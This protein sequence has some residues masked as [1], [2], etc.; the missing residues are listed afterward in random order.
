MQSLAPSGASAVYV[1]QRESSETAAARRLP[2]PTWCHSTRCSCVVLP[3]RPL[4]L[5]AVRHDLG[6]TGSAE[7]LLRAVYQAF[8]HLWNGIKF[9]VA[10]DKLKA[11]F[12]IAAG[13]AASAAIG[14]ATGGASVAVQVAAGLAASAVG[15]AA[16]GH[17][18]DNWDSWTSSEKERYIRQNG[19]DVEAARK[20][21]NHAAN[22]VQRQ[23]RQGRSSRS[24]GSHVERNKREYWVMTE[25]EF[26]S[27]RSSRGGTGM[28]GGRWGD[29]TL[30]RGWGD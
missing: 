28:G 11:A 9:I 4:A 15:S 29:G 13:Y 19:L 26:W 12:K 1:T 6:I 3:I 10:D 16:A 24:I 30:M 21:M 7:V 23:Q 18:Y 2:A 17:V 27:T 20:S 22:D 25:Q 8:G 14:L 5:H